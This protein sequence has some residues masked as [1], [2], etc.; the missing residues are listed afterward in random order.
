MTYLIKFRRLAW[1]A[2]VKVIL[3]FKAENESRTVFWRTLQQK[4]KARAW[5]PSRL[6]NSPSF[7]NLWVCA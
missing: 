4:D 5:K 1:F 2:L 3:L 7:E 6:Y